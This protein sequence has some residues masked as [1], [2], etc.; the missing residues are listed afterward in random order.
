MVKKKKGGG[1]GGGGGKGI[2]EFLQFQ[3]QSTLYLHFQKI[4]KIINGRMKALFCDKKKKE[5]RN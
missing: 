1:G 4:P 2:S 5:K 3:Y